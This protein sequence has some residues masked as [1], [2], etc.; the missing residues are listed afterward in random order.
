MDDMY[1]KLHVREAQLLAATHHPHIVCCFGVAKLPPA[2]IPGHE[3]SRDHPPYYLATVLELSPVRMAWHGPMDA[4][5]LGF[6]SRVICQ[7]DGG[8]EGW[9]C[10]WGLMLAMPQTTSVLHTPMPQTASV[11]GNCK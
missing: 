11:H 4:D 7:N 6:F 10:S 3:H 5:V 1:Y 8:R 2:A 9:V